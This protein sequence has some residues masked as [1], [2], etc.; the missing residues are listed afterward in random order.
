[1][2][3]GLVKAV[4]FVF[5]PLIAACLLGGVLMLLCVAWPLIPFMTVKYKQGD[6]E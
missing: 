5:W 3:D 6:A 4:L 1:M 2:R